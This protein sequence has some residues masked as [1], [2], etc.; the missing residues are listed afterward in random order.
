M[1]R[2]PTRRKRWKLN[3]FAGKTLINTFQLTTWTITSIY[4]SNK[5]IN[6][7]IRWFSNYWPRYIIWLSIQNKSWNCWMKMGCGGYSWI[8]IKMKDCKMKCSSSTG[9]IRTV[10]LYWR[11][12]RGG[13]NWCLFK[14]YSS[15]CTTVSN[16]NTFLST[17]H[18][19]PW[20]WNKYCLSWLHSSLCSTSDN[21]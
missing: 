2:N 3:S 21:S 4:V 13:I 14:T 20:C 8:S 5:V 15:G 10:K 7:I 17:H 9:S 6:W 1:L 19:N 16:W 11:G 12:I 18:L